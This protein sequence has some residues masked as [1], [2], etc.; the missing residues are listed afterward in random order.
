MPTRL[1]ALLLTLAAG[2]APAGAPAK[3]PAAGPPRPVLDGFVL[4]PENRPIEG[5]LVAVHPTESREAPSSTRTDAKGAFHVDL[6]RSMLHDLRVEKTGLVAV[7]RRRVRPGVPI[8]VRLERG[9]TITGIVR[10]GVTRAPVTDVRVEALEEGRWGPQRG[11]TWEPEAGVIEAKTDKEGRFELQGVGLNL[12]NVSAAA[13]GF[14]RATRPNVRAGGHV[15]LVLFPGASISGL[16]L[17]PDAKP[18]A[19]ALVS[20]EAEMN[21]A[22]GAAPR[23]ET[24]DAQGRFAVAGAPAGRQSVTARLQGMAPAVAWIEVEPAADAAVELRLEPGATLTGRVLNASREPVRGGVAVQELGDHATPEGLAELLRADAGTDGRFRIDRVPAGSHALRVTSPGLTPRRVEFS[25]ESDVDL[26]DLTLDAGLAIRGRVRDRAG[27]GIGGA[28]IFG[29]TR[30]S[31]AGVPIDTTS[32]DDG[33]FAIGGLQPGSYRVMI[34]ASGFGL[35]QRDLE[36]KS[37]PVEIVLDP[38]GSIRGCAVDAAGRPV[39]SYRVEAQP[40]SRTTERLTP[41]RIENVGAVD[42]CFGLE[43]VTEGRYILSV[44]APDHPA[45]TVSDVKVTAGAS[46]D[47]G[48]VRLDR[49]GMVRGTVVD[50]AGG[51]ILGATVIVAKAGWSQANSNAVTDANGTFELSGLAG[52]ALELTASHPDYAAGRAT[53][54]E[55][56]PEQGPAEAR[57]ILTAGGRVEGSLR[58]RD[59]T[60]VPKSMVAIVPLPP[61]GGF[62]Y[63]PDMMHPMRDDGSFASEHLT[64]GRYKVMVMAGNRSLYT[65]AQERDVDVREGETTAVEFVTRDIL[66]TGRVT[67]SGVPA[68]GLRISLRPTQLQMGF[69]LMISTSAA[70]AGEEAGPQRLVGTTREDGTYQLMADEPGAYSVSV[71]TVDGSVSFQPRTADLPDANTYVLDL[72]FS[73][74]LLAGVVVD[75]AT[76]KPLVDA[77]ISANAKTKGEHAGAFA[78]M[79]PDGR[80]GLELDPG[81]YVV[82][83]HCQGYGELSQDVTLPESGLDGLRLALGKGVVL[84]GKVVDAG[85]RPA[86][87]AQVIASTAQ[88]DSGRMS[89][90]SGSTAGD[91][92]FRLEGVQ[93][94]P[95]N[96]AAAQEGR[97]ALLR[98]VTPGEAGVILVLRPGGRVLLTLRDAGG[99]PVEGAWTFASVDGVP[100][101]TGLPATSGARGTVEMSVPAGSVT[102]HAM[103]GNLHGQTVFDVVEGGSVSQDIVLTSTR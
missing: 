71:A 21:V 59:G 75:Q 79:G 55:I 89:S 95:Q 30:S 38:A 65:N 51:G 39:T 77:F 86:A 52:G 87:G 78:R 15:T 58:K 24:T 93:D 83:A 6:K 99:A 19:G 8:T 44:T 10:D 25:I 68:P 46:T 92:S 66:V 49:G 43:D 28:R 47:V 62:T 69:T 94:E 96:V 97:F 32:E 74:A 53:G 100:V 80:F 50:A 17:G 16:V 72:D 22:A 76:G 14:S 7:T 103:A 31:E 33:S 40:A 91:G 48:R 63:S 12:M 35:A 41:P 88:N 11:A 101:P 1:A 23:T 34:Q 5:A 42:G 56:D 36:A 45:A 37:E 73:G 84:A 81:E 64:P 20:T 29:F 4:S 61:G 2:Q 67:R 70:G 98:N 90:L 54:I 9:G 57:I 3:P 60:P 82:S 27:V 85:G 13:P 18:V 102:V 26:G